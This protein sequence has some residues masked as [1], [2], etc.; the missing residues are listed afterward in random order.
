MVLGSCGGAEEEVVTPTTEE[1]EA[2]P[3]TGIVVIPG[4]DEEEEEEAAE[5]VP[6]GPVMV[7]D[8][9]G[10]LVEA[11][12]YGG[13]LY[14]EW[15][16]NADAISPARQHAPCRAKELVYEW[17][18]QAD[19]TRGP[20]GTG[21]HPY[22]GTFIGG[23]FLIGCIA[24]SWEMP[25]E[26][27]M[28]YNIREG[29]RWQ[30][31][32]PAWGREYT[33]EDFVRIAMWNRVTPWSYGYVDP[34]TPEEDLTK[35][36]L[37][38]DMTVR[39]TYTST[40]PL[41][42]IVW[43]WSWQAAPEQLEHITAEGE[44]PWENDWRYMCGTG[45]FM[46]KDYVEDSAWE[47]VRNDL[48]W[49]HDPMHPDNQL[50]YIDR[51]VGLV[52][53]DVAVYYSALQTGK[54]DVAR[55]A[56]WQ[57]AETFQAQYPDMLWN[58]GSARG[59]VLWWMVQKEPFGDVRVRQALTMA[60]NRQKMIETYYGGYAVLN[61]YPAQPGSEGYIP[62]EDMPADLQ[63][64]YLW[65]PENIEDAKAL[66]ADAGYPN[67]F[68]TETHVSNDTSEE[69]MLIVA[70]D[71]AEI[72]VDLEVTRIDGATMSGMVWNKTSPAMVYTACGNS[73]P[74]VGLY[75][76]GGGYPPHLANFGNIVDPVA[77]EEF[78]QWTSM[79]STEDLEERSQLLKSAYLRQIGLCWTAAMPASVPTNA[80]WPWVKNFY[81]T[82][83]LG[84]NADVG[85]GLHFKYVWIDRDLKYQMTGTRE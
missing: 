53:P 46:L 58:Y 45:P 36:E 2:A 42:P 16:A 20:A 59:Q 52:I 40:S 31:K 62:V 24:E 69:V 6:T 26:Y 67:G 82:F 12:Q 41:R 39:I 22:T 15:E 78:E 1:E 79:W 54:L 11:P 63:R 8:S 35:I 48:Y 33:G 14:L 51:I 29:V 37:I 47:Y 7:Y 81:G 25:D 56:D 4:A 57:K 76:Q 27:T 85:S 32:A 75:L 61:N 18:H 71:L 73:M 9:Q 64:Y 19:W 43:D 34:A 28:I 30:N 77:E 83:S 70:D 10:N 38:D 5:V 3:T 17:V 66:L 49:M 13:T 65:K 74:H 84:Y 68:K 72:G 23:S 55:V 50:P 60:I 80:W 21:E 44:L